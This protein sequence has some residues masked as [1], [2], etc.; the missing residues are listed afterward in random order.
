E[1]DNLADHPKYKGKLAE[2]RGELKK[3]TMAQGDEL[4]PHRDPYL[5]SAP[6]PEIKRKPKKKKGK[7]KPE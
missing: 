1:L 7:P 2:L 3:W 5:A 4:L 6:I